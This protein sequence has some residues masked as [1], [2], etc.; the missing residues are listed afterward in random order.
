MNNAVTP[1]FLPVQVC[2]C[3]ADAISNV[4]HLTTCSNGML[5]PQVFHPTGARNTVNSKRINGAALEMIMRDVL[6]GMQS[7]TTDACS[8]SETGRMDIL[9][10]ED[11]ENSIQEKAAV[12]PFPGTCKKS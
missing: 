4:R 7:F 2:P 1:A 10:V 9:A 6:H 3:C 11:A 5:K 12:I 8:G